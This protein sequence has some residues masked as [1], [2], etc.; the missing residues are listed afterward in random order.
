MTLLGKLSLQRKVALFITAILVVVFALAIGTLLSIVAPRL[1]QSLLTS[2]TLIGQ[3]LIK[4]IKVAVDLG[5]PLTSLEG[6]DDKLNQAVSQYPDHGY[7]YIADDAG[8]ILYKSRL[9]EGKL[10]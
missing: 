2:S 8:G 1:R 9:V 4:D 10:T 7:V 3:I 6:V 5:V